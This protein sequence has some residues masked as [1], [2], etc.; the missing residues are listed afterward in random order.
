MAGAGKRSASRTPRVSS[1]QTQSKG[2][3]TLAMMLR[4]YGVEHEREYRWLEGRRY[5][6][7]FAIPAKRLLVEVQG[8]HWISGRHNRGSGYA[9]DLVRM[10]LA[11]LAGWTVLQYT[12]DMVVSGEAI[13]QIMEFLQRGE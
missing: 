2:E 4:A 11:Q 8:G 7:D 12:T 5:R 9:Q 3:A 1:E 6:S 13:A 10:N